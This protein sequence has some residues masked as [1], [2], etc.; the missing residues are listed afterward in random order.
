MAFQEA[1][2]ALY[3]HAF[4]DSSGYPVVHQGSGSNHGLLAAKTHLAKK[5]LTIPRLELVSAH[6]AANLVENV[7][8][9]LQG[10][11]VKSVYRWLDSTKIREKDFLEQRRV[12]TSQNPV[13]TA[14]EVVNETDHRSCG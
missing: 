14:A 5:G 7:K 2:D 12:C 10:Q 11:P 9:S 1:T 4:G 13:N 6:K 8:N 3:L